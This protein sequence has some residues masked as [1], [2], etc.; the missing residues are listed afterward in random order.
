M[1]RFYDCDDVD[2]TEADRQLK[3]Y[4]EAKKDARKEEKEKAKERFDDYKLKLN[5]I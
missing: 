5:G 2:Y 4:E 3:E 1:A